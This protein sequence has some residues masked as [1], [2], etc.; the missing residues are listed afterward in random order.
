M[1]LKDFLGTISTLTMQSQGVFTKYILPQL[2]TYFS[3]EKS[4]NVTRVIFCWSVRHSS[5]VTKSVRKHAV[6]IAAV[7]EELL[8]N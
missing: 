5:T 4:Q 7:R 8:L 2:D 3:L 1:L 6:T